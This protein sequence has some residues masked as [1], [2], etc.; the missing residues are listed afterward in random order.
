MRIVLSVLFLW[1]IGIMTLL[2]ESP[3]YTTVK[4]KLES[5]EM[6]YRINGV[7]GMNHG[8]GNTYAVCS[9]FSI[10]K[11]KGFRSNL[12]FKSCSHSRKKKSDKSQNLCRL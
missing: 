4:W 12:N 7:V 8:S 3:G 1:K 6:A 11:G 9:G 2:V 10:G 5:V